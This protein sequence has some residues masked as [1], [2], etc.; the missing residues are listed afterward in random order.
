MKKEMEN[1][2]TSKYC[3]GCEQEKTRDKFYQ[4]EG[5]YRDGLSP[6]CKVCQRANQKKYSSSKHTRREPKSTRRGRT[7]LAAAGIPCTTGKAAGYEWVDLAAWG[8]IPIEAK[9]C[10]ITRR[11]G[12]QHVHW[13]FSHKQQN[14]GFEDG[15]FLLLAWFKDDAL[16]MRSFIVPT[17]EKWATEHTWSRRYGWTK[18]GQPK[19][20]LGM[21]IDS[22]LGGELW[23][24][25]SAFENRFD[26]I[27][28]KR[29]EI[30]TSLA[31]TKPSVL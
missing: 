31:A 15:F 2:P 24:K 13:A 19:A 11:N 30:A 26:L 21:A 22:R 1:I 29:L 3:P 23:S 16:P 8:C 14:D 7:I 18:K 27:E 28:K 6:Y 4:N 5:C 17:S 10:T 25:L 9:G 12:N 20:A